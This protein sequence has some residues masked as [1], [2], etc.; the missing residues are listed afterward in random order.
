MITQERRMEL[1]AELQRH[2]KGKPNN[3]E[4]VSLTELRDLDVAL[5]DRDGS[6]SFRIALRNRIDELEA[7]DQRSHEGKV[8]AWQLVQAEG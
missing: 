4:S 8:R 5:G 6:A 2:I 7:A 3:L 1:V